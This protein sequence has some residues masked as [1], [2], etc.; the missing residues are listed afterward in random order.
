VVLYE[1]NRKDDVKE[2]EITWSRKFVTY[3][4]RCSYVADSAQKMEVTSPS[5][6]SPQ[7][8]PHGAKYQKMTFFSS[9]VRKIYL[10]FIFISGDRI[11][12]L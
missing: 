10:H 1:C 5:Q 7:Q 6:T 11:S 4:Q 12:R 3:C 9:A 8:Y 2:D